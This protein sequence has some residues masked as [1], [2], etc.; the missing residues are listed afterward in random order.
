MFLRLWLTI[1]VPMLEWPSRV[2][3]SNSFPT[4]VIPESG[5]LGSCN[6]KTGDLHFE[7]VPLLIANIVGFLFAGVGTFCLIQIIIAGYEFALG[8][9][10]GGSTDK[11]KQRMRNALIGLVVS[12]LSYAIVNFLLDSLTR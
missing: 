12:V 8:S 10:L 1:I 4:S 2:L 11:G 6:F 5:T 3:A 9:A 7:C